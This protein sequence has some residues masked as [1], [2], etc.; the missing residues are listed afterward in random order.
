[1]RSVG[2][3]AFCHKLR[4][5][6]RELFC[7]YSQ[8]ENILLSNADYNKLQF[9]QHMIFI[10]M[11]GNDIKLM[12]SLH[13]MQALAA[14]LATHKLDREKNQFSSNLLTAFLKEY[15]NIIAG[16]IK[17]M[18][19]AEQVQIGHS[20]PIALQGFNELFF[21]ENYTSDHTSCWSLKNQQG[22]EFDLCLSIK[23]RI[24]TNL[25]YIQKITFSNNEPIILNE[26]EIF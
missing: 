24:D 12:Y 11:S 22:G 7:L 15:V 2:L 19:L 1:M 9:K 25:D 10:M 21:R 4:S 8:Q 14:K 26:L 13:Y 16:N 3:D 5:I 20:L 18:F 17:A 6:S 23:L